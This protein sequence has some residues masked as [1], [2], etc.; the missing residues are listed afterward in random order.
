MTKGHSGELAREIANQHRDEFGHFP[1]WDKNICLLCGRE[2]LQARATKVDPFACDFADC[3]F[4]GKHVCEKG[5]STAV[6]EGAPLCECGHSD[7]LHDDGR[8]CCSHR[9]SANR[10]CLCQE[11]KRVGE[12]AGTRADCSYCGR[13]KADTLHTSDLGLLSYSSFTHDD[14]HHF[15]E[16]GA[17]SDEDRYSELCAAIGFSDAERSWDTLIG[18]I[19][20]EHEKL[21]QSERSLQEMRAELERLKK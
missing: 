6:V 17:D 20:G 3:S 2:K 9:Y 21:E 10:M 18:W 15:A 8:L 7:E 1:Q 19:Q 12:G 11:F 13:P 4:A 5:A 16:P 14:Y